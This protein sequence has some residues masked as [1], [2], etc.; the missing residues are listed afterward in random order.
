MIT[1][2]ALQKRIEALEHNLNN[3]ID[4]SANLAQNLAEALGRINELEEKTKQH[5]EA[6]EHVDEHVKELF[7]DAIAETAKEWNKGLEDVINFNPY[8]VK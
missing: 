2:T 6:F 1:K 3:Q 5:D 4:Y 7:D 8:G